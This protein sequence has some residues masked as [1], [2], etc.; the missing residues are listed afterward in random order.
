MLISI[1]AR[2]LGPKG[3]GIYGTVTIFVTILVTFFN[4]GV[5]SSNAYFI[6]R[7]KS[8]LP[9]AFKASI[10]SWLNLSLLGVVSAFILISLGSKR[11]FP[12]VPVFLLYFSLILFPILLFNN[13]MLGIFQATENFRYLNIITL[14][15]VVVNLTLILGIRV[16]SQVNITG[17]LLCFMFSQFIGSVT[18][19]LLIKYRLN[20]NSTE[21]FST[22]DIIDY[23]KSMT[24]YSTIT[25]ASNVV[26]YLNYRAD[27]YIVISILGP[28]S[29]GIYFLAVQ[30]VERLWVVA[31]SISYVM[32]PRLS[33]GVKNDVTRILVI[34]LAVISFTV[35]LVLACVVAFMSKNYLGTVFGNNYEYASI[36]IIILLPGIVLGSLSK[37]FSNAIAAYGAVKINFWVSVLLLM[38]NISLSLSLTRKFGLGG[39]AVATSISYG[40]DGVIKTALGIKVLRHT[41]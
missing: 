20:F 33:G 2:T 5:N 28:T 34:K 6:S 15:P 21:R 32:L 8:V 3:N 24:K 13:I 23:V 7:Q 37:I 35:T 39:A 12:D 10:F 4:F 36:P 18:I 9:L 29:A 31:Q 25:H 11:V 41:V 38:I 1:I 16:F 40:I 26:T 19:V 30:I 17:T 14:L 22:K 27:F